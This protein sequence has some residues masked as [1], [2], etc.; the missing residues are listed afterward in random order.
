MEKNAKTE[1]YRIMTYRFFG[2]GQV[3]FLQRTEVRFLNGESI[4]RK[5]FTFLRIRAS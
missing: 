5:P 3:K 1:A 2:V 4:G